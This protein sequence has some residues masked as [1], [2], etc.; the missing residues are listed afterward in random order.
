MDTFVLPLFSK[1]KVI[2][3]SELRG[4]IYDTVMRIRL[5]GIFSYGWMN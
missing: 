1:G 2:I 5:A 3:K 4:V